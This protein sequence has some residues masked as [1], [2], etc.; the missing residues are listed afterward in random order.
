MGLSA[1]GFSNAEL[2]RVATLRA[3]TALRQGRELGSIR[4]GKLADI[5]LVEGDPLEEISALAHVIAVM[6]DG[7]LYRNMPALRAE[8]PFLPN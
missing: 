7:V 1:I 2:L 4:V 8:L 6:K 5:I 3:A